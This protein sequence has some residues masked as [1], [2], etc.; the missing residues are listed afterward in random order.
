MA[1]SVAE[2]IETQEV[3]RWGRSLDMATSSKLRIMISSRCNDRFPLKDGGPLSEIRREL[4][5]EI[6]NL[7][8]FGKKIFEVWINEDAPPASGTE[9][10]W[11]HCLMQVEQC[12]A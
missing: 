11:E 8:V 6:E 10:S 12:A 4:K 7:E 5:K 1:I 9:D 3:Y 2:K